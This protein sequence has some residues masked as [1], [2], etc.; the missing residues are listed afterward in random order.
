[1]KLQFLSFFR[2][3]TYFQSYSAGLFKMRHPVYIVNVEEIASWYFCLQGGLESTNHLVTQKLCLCTYS[4][5]PRMLVRKR[6]RSVE[7]KNK[8]R[9][10][11][12]F[13][14]RSTNSYFRYKSCFIFLLRLQSF[15]ISEISILHRCSK[16]RKEVLSEVR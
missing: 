10:E 8:Y 11:I 16:L 14:F 15:T 13:F 2:F 12:W 1:M 3:R 4:W 6:K 5:P 9:L 7:G